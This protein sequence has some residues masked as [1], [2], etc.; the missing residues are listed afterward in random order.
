MKKI[1]KMNNR[2]AETCG[3]HEII[4]ACCSTEYS[5][6]RFDKKPGS[7]KDIDQQMTRVTP[8]CQL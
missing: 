3:K 5:Y 6:G 1:L 2:F 7:L 4:I 8:F